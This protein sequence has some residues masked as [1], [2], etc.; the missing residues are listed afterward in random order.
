MVNYRKILQLDADKNVSVRDLLT[1]AHC[2]FRSYTSTIEAAKAKGIKWPLDDICCIIKVP[3]V[4]EPKWRTL[5]LQF[6]ECCS[7][8]A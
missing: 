4:A 2:S 7:E 6:G 1:S 8:I 3:K 5:H